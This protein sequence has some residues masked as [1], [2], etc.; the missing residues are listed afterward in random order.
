MKISLTRSVVLVL[1]CGTVT[2]YAFD[3]GPDVPPKPAPPRYFETQAA[4]LP[5][6]IPTASPA[7]RVRA[8]DSPEGLAAIV[9][10]FQA[11]ECS[12]NNHCGGASVCD[13]YTVCSVWSSMCLIDERSGQGRCVYYGFCPG[14]QI[15]R[16]ER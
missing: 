7:P 11:D 15:Y 3:S 12:S 4:C 10:S 13:P 16:G 1:L 14:C 8:D 5:A 2:A 9:R 6:P